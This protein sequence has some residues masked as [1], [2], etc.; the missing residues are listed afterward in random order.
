MLVYSG[1][2]GGGGGYNHYYD[3]TYLKKFVKK[4]LKFQLA[5]FFFLFSFCYIFDFH[6][7]ASFN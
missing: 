2:G 5:K 6:L 4:R 3:Y 1:G 7:V